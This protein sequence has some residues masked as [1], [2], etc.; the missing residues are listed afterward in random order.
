MPGF[1]NQSTRT[2]ARSPGFSNPP[3]DLVQFI[4]SLQGLLP[5]VMGRRSDETTTNFPSGSDTL[6]TRILQNGMSDLGDSSRIKS[7]P[8]HHP[9]SPSHAPGGF[10]SCSFR[11]WKAESSS[12][13]IFNILKFWTESS[14]EACV[15]AGR[16][17]ARAKPLLTGVSSPRLEQKCVVTSQHPRGMV[18]RPV[19][20]LPRGSEYEV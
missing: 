20:P 13:V 14:F 2:G 17:G 6:C 5:S 4:S 3:C 16:R 9:L 7:G 10:H 18:P 8:L 1:G 15:F 11:H 12:T 19:G